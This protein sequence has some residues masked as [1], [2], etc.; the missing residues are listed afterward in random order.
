MVVNII[1]Q[2]RLSPLPFLGKKIISI[3]H[4]KIIKGTLAKKV[5]NLKNIVKGWQNNL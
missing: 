3:E 1:Q 5:I 4:K 2:D